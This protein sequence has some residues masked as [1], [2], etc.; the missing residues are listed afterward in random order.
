MRENIQ[1]ACREGY[2]QIVVH[3][4]FRTVFSDIAEDV[5]HDA[6]SFV[7]YQPNISLEIVFKVWRLRHG[8]Y[9]RECWSSDLSVP[10]S[11]AA[12]A[13]NVVV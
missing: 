13:R 10:F 1:L 11:V 6:D 9:L 4:D 12:S 8:S 7:P 3:H 2:I 5:E